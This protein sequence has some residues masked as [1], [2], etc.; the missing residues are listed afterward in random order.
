VDEVGLPVVLVKVDKV[1]DV[2]MSVVLVKVD[3]VGLL[4]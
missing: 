3:E 1:D 2:G 4:G